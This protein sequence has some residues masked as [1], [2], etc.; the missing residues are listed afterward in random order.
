MKS[1]DV[2]FGAI[3][4]A[5]AELSKLIKTLVAMLRNFVDSWKKVPAAANG[6]Q[7][8]VATPTDL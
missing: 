4:E 7:V 3:T 5:I 2:H 6:D 1:T 8:P